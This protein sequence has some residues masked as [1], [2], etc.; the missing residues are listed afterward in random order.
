MNKEILHLWY[1]YPD[2]LL[3]EEAVE[4]CAR[5]L[6]EEERARWQ[7]FKFD[8]HRREY[9]ATHALAR[10][11]LS[12]HGPLPPEAWR[13]EINAYGKPA[14]EPRCGLCFN[15]SNSPGLVVCLI[16]QGAE[17]GVDVEPHERAGSIAEVG[18]RMFSLRELEQLGDL[19]DYERPERALRLWT[20]KEAY[21]KA[22][23]MGLAL[24]LNKFSF[25]FE[26]AERIRME[27]DA[28][29]GDEPEHWQFCLMDQRGH[30][31]AL[32]VE[33]GTAP[34]LHVW[35][36]RPLLAPATKLVAGK[37]SWFPVPAIL[38]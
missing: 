12:Y 1:A 20:L 31:I 24:P 30:C 7:T 35:E 8:R 5:L 2:D 9:L 22:R 4:A 21:I 16:S 19:R 10:T 23:G 25:L 29:L 36:T 14:I 26:G 38:S 34:E 6:S 3:E 32:M 18:P 13:F 37:E 17:V 15:L 33:S 28:S 11:A 27:L